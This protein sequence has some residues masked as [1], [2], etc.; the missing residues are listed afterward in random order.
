MKS[1][2]SLKKMA[3]MAVVF[4]V[5]AGWVCSMASAAGMA[6]PAAIPVTKPIVLSM[7]M[8]VPQEASETSAT[9][10][11][12]ANGGGVFLFNP[13][14]DMLSYAIAYSGLSG[15]PTM[16]HFHVGASTTNGPIAQTL[17]GMPKPLLNGPC[18]T[19][20]SGMLTGTW[21][22]PQDQVAR[23]LQGGIYVNFHTTLNPGGEIRGQVLPN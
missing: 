22:V 7:H 14:T 9:T 10:P 20:T 13:Q 2:T 21:H 18:P 1:L 15:A 4:G 3:S 8:G 23:L 5:G 16:A 19:T 11:A 17:C 6:M 12:I